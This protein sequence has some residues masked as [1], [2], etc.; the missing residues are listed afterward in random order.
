MSKREVFKRFAL[1]AALAAGVGAPVL[2]EGPASDPAKV[3]AGTYA[4]EPGHTMVV[5]GVSHMGF[6]TYYGSFTGAS[7]SLEL[8]TEKPDSSRL[9]VSVA[10]ASVMVPSDKLKEELKSA[11]WLDAAK[12]PEVTFHST[13]IKRTGKDSATVMGELTLH[14]VT[15]PVTLTAHFMGAGTNPIDKKYTVGFEV[16]GKIM[17]SEF[18]VKTYVPLIGD[19]VDLRIS[20]AFEKQG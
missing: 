20:G 6:T 16:N 13:S 14:G 8:S 4:V 2:A 5:F 18:G 15:K 17:R 7:G 9:S 11:D 12:F 3:E 19:E 10:T 1:A